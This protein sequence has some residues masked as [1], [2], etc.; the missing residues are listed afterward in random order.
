[1]L[2]VRLAV[3]SV[4]VVAPACA[5]EPAGSLVDRTVSVDTPIRSASS[6]ILIGAANLGVPR[7]SRGRGDR[8]RCVRLDPRLEPL[9]LRVE[10]L[11]ALERDKR[12]QQPPHPCIAMAAV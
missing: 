2:D 1:M 11:F 12:R 8:D 3:L 6:P 5:R 4:G 7:M 10:A 9:Q